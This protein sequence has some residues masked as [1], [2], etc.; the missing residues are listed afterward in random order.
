[1]NTYTTKA[2]A[3]R[4]AKNAGLEIGAF[5]IKEVEG[6]YAFEVIAPV[7]EELPAPPA[8]VEVPAELLEG[9]SAKSVVE[10]PVKRV[11]AIAD[12]MWGAR[13]KDVI[14]ACVAEGIAYN[15]ART[16]YQAFFKVKS[17]EG[18]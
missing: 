17:L 1:M 8:E 12:D 11:W 3:K 7:K 13:R 14:A 18:K 6:R 16:Q 9:T 5:E 15:T 4:A 10:N 2:N